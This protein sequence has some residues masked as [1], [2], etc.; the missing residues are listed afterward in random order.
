MAAPASSFTPAQRLLLVGSP[1]G[2]HDQR[3]RDG[4]ERQSP[5]RCAHLR[6]PGGKAQEPTNRAATSSGPQGNHRDS[7]ELPGWVFLPPYKQVHRTST[8]DFTAVVGAV[9]SGTIAVEHSFPLRCGP[10][11]VNYGPQVVGVSYCCGKPGLVRDGFRTLELIIAFEESLS[12]QE[13]QDL[14]D[15]GLVILDRLV[16]LNAYLVQVLDRWEQDWCGLFRTWYQVRRA[17]W[18]GPGP[19]CSAQR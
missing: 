16:F 10:I 11:Q 15:L 9:L 3:H 6:L 1:P 7:T 12:A 8:V 13:H 4:G 5:G 18:E 2:I 19:G 17:Q 14:E